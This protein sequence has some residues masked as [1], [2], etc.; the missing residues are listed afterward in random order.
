[1]FDKKKWELLAD[2]HRYEF[3]P[4]WNMSHNLRMQILTEN[5]SSL[6]T[7][8]NLSLSLLTRLLHCYFHVGCV[9]SALRSLQVSNTV[10][11]LIIKYFIAHQIKLHS[12]TNKFTFRWNVSSSVFVFSC[13]VDCRVRFATE[14]D[15]HFKRSIRIVCLD[16]RRQTP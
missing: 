13:V 9:L 15:F 1:M 14:I 8:E 10:C 2:L 3:E 4:L 6:V 12:T 16:F 7:E 11:L 5:A